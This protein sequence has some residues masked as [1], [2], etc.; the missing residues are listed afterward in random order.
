M[1]FLYVQSLLRG[2]LLSKFYEKQVI[3]MILFKKI[4]QCRIEDLFDLY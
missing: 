3:I 2:I 1:T 4:E